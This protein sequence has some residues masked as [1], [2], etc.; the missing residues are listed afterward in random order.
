MVRI[1]RTLGLVVCVSCAALAGCRGERPD[2]DTEPAPANETTST[3]NVEHT[4]EIGAPPEEPGSAVRAKL[5]SDD[6]LVITVNPSGITWVNG[7][8]AMLADLPPALQR[9]REK[10]GGTL[11]VVLF[12]AEAEKT[13]F[14]HF[15]EMEQLMRGMGIEDV[16][17]VYGGAGF[18][19]LAPTPDP[20]TPPDPPG[21]G[22]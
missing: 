6:R 15:Q 14:Q 7:Q 20:K 8:I 3:E 4:P 17:T 10:R 18:E 12:F 13:N 21:E 19:G 9:E 22:G 16:T 2:N 1:V 11:K 5:E